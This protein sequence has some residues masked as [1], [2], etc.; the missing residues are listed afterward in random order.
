[1][2]SAAERKPRGYPGSIRDAPYL[3]FHGFGVF[4]SP[5]GCHDVGTHGLW[6]PKIAE[7]W[8]LDAIAAVVIGGAVCLAAEAGLEKRW[9]AC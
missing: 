5:G 4:C 3:S 1:M 2:R 8:E 9:S 7:G 6:G